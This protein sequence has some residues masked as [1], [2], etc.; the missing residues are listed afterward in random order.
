MTAKNKK[1]LIGIVS[2][3][4]ILVVA[5]LAFII[6][7]ITSSDDAVTGATTPVMTVTT[8]RTVTAARNSTTVANAE[9][10]TNPA[11]QQPAH[12]PYF[13]IGAATAYVEAQGDGMAAIDPG[14]TWQPGSTLHVIHA[15][16]VGSA[17]YGG[18]F[19]YFF[20][21]G[22]LVGEHAFTS[23]QTAQT[24]NGTT[25]A[26]TFNVYLPT[27]PHCCPTGGTSTVQFHWDGSALVSSG[28]MAG[29]TM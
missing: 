15:T 1:I 24:V 19:Y 6:G 17:S 26:V 16:P 4:V 18:D 5:L 20:V 7:R 12:G 14:T 3:A 2:A 22:Y 23:A 28:S 9:E 29:A 11:S 25:Y 13:T 8:T 27:D 21:D 10:D